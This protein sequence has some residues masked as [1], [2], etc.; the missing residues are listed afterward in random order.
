MKIDPDD[1]LHHSEVARPHSSRRDT[2]HLRADL[3]RWLAGH[4]AEPT[5]H[6]VRRPD[7]TGMSSETLLF[8]AEWD[9]RIH[10]LVARVAPAETSVPVF[11]HYDLESQCRVM[12]AVAAHTDVPVPHVQWS[13]PDVAPLGAP[14]FVMT[15]VDGRVPPDVM[16]YN[17]GSWVTEAEPAQRATM[18][19]AAVEVLAQVHTVD[20]ACLD[21]AAAG[22]VPTVRDAV[23]THLD[24]QR[25][26][27]EWTTVTGPRSPLIERAFAWLDRHLPDDREPAVL[28]WGDARIGNILFED[29]RPVAVLDW[30]LAAVGAREMDI[31]W[32]IFLHRFFEDLAA[33][34]GLPGLPD[35]LRRGDIADAYAART[36]HTPQ[37]LDFYTC[38]AAL[39][40]A[41]IML[42]IA[43]R[44]VHFGQA[45][46]P[47]DVDAMILHRDS[48][49]AML[50]GTYWESLQ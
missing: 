37:H 34:A 48:L 43:T 27:Y 5:V 20:P 23:R 11:P 1:S 49:Q 50:D 32:M 25:A 31:A 41:I 10:A 45:E 15:H 16:P 42:R 33:L 22:T 13:E 3:Q 28:C 14:F 18:Q 40:H 35:F 44:A 17:F 26:Y 7:A 12:R 36:G 6:E 21:P 47:D 29:F 39:Q 30:E 2:D 24:E 4:V 8:D 9:G 19:D 46:Q 38:Y